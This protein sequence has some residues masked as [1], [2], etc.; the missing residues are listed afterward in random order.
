M[1]A[2]KAEKM[3]PYLLQGSNAS[4]EVVWFIQHNSSTSGATIND[5]EIHG[6][7]KGVVCTAERSACTVSTKANN[8]AMPEGEGEGEAELV[9]C[10]WTMKSRMNAWD[11]A[12]YRSL[13][14]HTK[15]AFLDA[16]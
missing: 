3:S 4:L 11:A 2:L 9:E 14:I 15:P 5:R 6:Y 1:D 7:G 10:A 16:V 13:Q 8:A 12:C